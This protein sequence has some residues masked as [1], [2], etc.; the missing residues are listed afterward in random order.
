MSDFSNITPATLTLRNA[1]IDGRGIATT[2]VTYATSDQATDAPASGWQ[3]VMPNVD[4][5][6]YL[7]TRIY[8]TYTDGTAPTTY[9]TVSLQGKDGVSAFKSIVFKRSA[10]T[11]STPTGGSYTSPVPSGWSDGIPTED[12][13]PCYMSTRIFTNTGASPQQSVWTTPQ[14]CTD[15]A[16]FDI[17]FYPA[18]DTTPAEPSTHGTQGETATTWHDTALTTD[19]W[20][21]T[22]TR[23]NGGTWSDWSIVKIKGEKG[24]DGLTVQPNLINGSGFARNTSAWERRNNVTFYATG[25]ALSGAGYASIRNYAGA[26]ITSTYTDNLEQILYTADEARK[27]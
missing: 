10:S 21:A 1:A 12:G 13:N 27:K 25:G 5:G 23:E 8:I 17:C 22:A 9:Y 7:W 15:T 18:S 24:A 3:S 16:D 20:M 4:E 26:I 6:E 14:P 19:E 2:T 11:P